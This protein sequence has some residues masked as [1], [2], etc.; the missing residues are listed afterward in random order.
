MNLT[1]EQQQRLLD[2]SDTG[3]ELVRIGQCIG[4]DA[5]GVV[6]RILGGSTGCETYI[7]SPDNFFRRLSNRLRD[8]DICQRWHKGK[9]VDLALEYGISPRRVLQIVSQQRN[10][11]EVD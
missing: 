9:T 2:S 6:L 4:A 7:P 1:P 10:M 3:N 8:Q 5:L 11:R